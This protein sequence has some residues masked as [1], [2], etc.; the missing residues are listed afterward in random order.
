MVTARAAAVILGAGVLALATPRS[1]PAQS[2]PDVAGTEAAVVADHP[3]AAAAGAEILRRGGN[4][5]DAAVAMAAVLAVVRPHMSGIGGDGFLLYRAAADGQV[6]ALNGSGRAPERATPA[7]FRERGLETVPTDGVLSVTVPGA[8]RLWV[9]ALRRFGTMPL[10]AVLA[11]AIAL[12]E[13]GFPVSSRLADEIADSRTRIERDAAMRAVFLPDG[14]VPPVGSLLRQR[15]LAATFRLIAADGPDVFY[16]GTIAQRI[17]AFMA[18]EGGLLR[19]EDLAGHSSAWQQPIATR[20]RGFRILT[21]PP[22]SG[23][24]ALLMLMNV[25][26]Q[27]EVEAMPHN[28]APYLHM[29]V[30][31]KKRVFA[32]RNRFVGDPAFTEIPIDA[33]LS[34]GYARQQAL[35]LGERAAPGEGVGAGTREGE[36]DTS[37]LGVIDRDGNAV[38][39]I[40]S[41]FQS[42]GS[43][44]M[45]PGTGIVLHNRGA[46]FSLDP[47]SVNVIAPRKRPYHSL[48]P[49]L[50]LRP[51]G[52]VFMVFGSPGGDTQAQT[53]LQVFNNVAL[54]GMTPQS[55]VEAPRFRSL[56]DGVLL[57]EEGF[58]AATRN[59][60]LARAHSLRVEAGITSELGAAQMIVVLPSGVRFTAA[61]PRLEAYGIAW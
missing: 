33:L 8:V 1:S 49:A 36:G 37:F 21:P 5:I 35:G 56:A 54:Y 52:S 2:R 48:V 46:Q 31:S 18:T 13:G 45:V 7:A 47:G 44:R 42:F 10:P 29:I 51:D 19:I 24:I 60:L 57:L 20:Y 26:E 12:A 39:L 6:Y 41:L 61:D 40:G 38:S 23:G 34:A 30:E 14:A 55:A 3:L 4:A 15:D 53:L 32:D 9:D 59:E 16:V 50:A 58:T 22:N 43:G 25:V 27:F 17:D 28:S 11:P